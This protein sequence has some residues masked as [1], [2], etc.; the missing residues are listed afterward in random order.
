VDSSLIFILKV[1]HMN[2]EEWN[3][4]ERNTEEKIKRKQAER[5][6]KEIRRKNNQKNENESENVGNDED[7]S[8]ESD[9]ET[10]EW[11]IQISNQEAFRQTIVLLL[12][13]RLSHYDTSLEEDMELLKSSGSLSVPVSRSSETSRSEVSGTHSKKRKAMENVQSPIKKQK[14][15]YIS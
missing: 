2:D 11:N 5:K 3:D 12:K 9:S 6:N 14:K 1:L 10:E 8:F 4:F 7:L 13:T 15:N